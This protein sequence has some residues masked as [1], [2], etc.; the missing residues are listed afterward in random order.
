M[1]LSL[2]QEPA[3][4]AAAAI[5]YDETMDVDAIFAETVAELRRDGVAVAGLLQKFVGNPCDARRSMW[6]ENLSSGALIRLDQP[7]GLGASACVLDPDALARAA[8]VLR[9]AIS[10][11]PDLILVNRFGHAEATGRGLRAEIAEAICAGVPLLIAVRYSLL[12]AWEGFLGGPAQ[13][14]LPSPPAVLCWVHDRVG[15]VREARLRAS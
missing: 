1:Q 10:S 5:V 6:L 3:V 12:P 2:V 11:G 7:R 8:C 13:I 14:L 9:Q 4:A 15:S